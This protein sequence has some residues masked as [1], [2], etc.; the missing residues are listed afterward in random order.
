MAGQDALVA[1]LRLL[2]LDEKLSV[3]IRRL[4]VTEIVVA[5]REQ[6]GGAVP[7]DE[8][9]K[10]RLAGVPVRSLEAFY[11]LLRGRVP[12]E[13]LKASWLIYGDGFRHNWWRVFEK[14]LIDILASLVLLAVFLPVMILAGIA[15][16]IESGFPVLYR[17]ERVGHGGRKFVIWKFRSMRQDAEADG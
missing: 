13:S 9:L 14:R 8:L 4:H 15:I 5:V 17:Q 1:S 7:M 3:A 16:A 12:V 2:S 6:R 10:C 11:E